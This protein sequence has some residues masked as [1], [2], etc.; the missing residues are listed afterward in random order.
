MARQNQGNADVRIVKDVK[1]ERFI[2]FDKMENIITFLLAILDSLD[3][4]MLEKKFALWYAYDVH[5]AAFM[6]QFCIRSMPP[7]EIKLSDKASR[8]LNKMLRKAMTPD[9]PDKPSGVG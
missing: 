9:L 6:K 3:L 8:Q 5:N 1:I 7:S 2:D 4:T